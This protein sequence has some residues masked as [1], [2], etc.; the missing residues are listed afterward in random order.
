MG[1][2]FDELCSGLAHYVLGRQPYSLHD[3]RGR[4]ELRLGITVV[5]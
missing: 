3:S 5:A 1:Q 4:E 2:S